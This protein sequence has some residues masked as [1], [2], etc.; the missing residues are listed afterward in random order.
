MNKK[1]NLMIIYFVISFI[2]SQI[3]I[4]FLS[5]DNFLESPSFIL[6]PI[7]GFF[8]LYLFTPTIMKDLKISKLTFIISFIVICFLGYYFGL[9]FYNYNI[10][11][12]LNNMS[13]RMNYFE[14]LFE[15][16]FFSMIVS[17][18]IGA[19]FSKK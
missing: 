13:I 12:I 7:V 4:F 11:V 18:T 2:V 15:S 3:A 17:G 6:L 8:S 1:I 9:F 19:F 14:M 5:K 16:A 10:Y